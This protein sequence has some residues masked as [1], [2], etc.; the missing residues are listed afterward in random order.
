MVMVVLFSLIPNGVCH[1][2]FLLKASKTQ[3]QEQIP[4]LY[5]LSIVIFVTEALPIPY[6]TAPWSDIKTTTDGL[7]EK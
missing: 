7:M 5:V 1:K 4:L 2:F 6:V 3:I